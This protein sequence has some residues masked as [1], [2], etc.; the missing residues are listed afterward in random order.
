M[1]GDRPAGQRRRGRLPLRGADRR[2]GRRRGRPRPAARR[3]SRAAALPDADGR[4]R[5][6]GAGSPSGCS[7]SPA[8][9]AL[10]WRMSATAI[11]PVKRFGARQA[12]AARALDRPPARGA[13][14]RRCSPTCS[15][16][17]TA[18]R[19]G[20]ADD[21]RHRRGPRRAARPPARAAR[22][23]AARGLRDPADP[24]T[25][26]RRCSGSSARWRSAPAARRCCPGDCP[27]LDPARA[28]R[29]L[30]RG[31]RPVRVAVVPDRHGTGTNALL[32]RPP[33]R[34]ARRSARAAAARTRTAA[35][36]RRPS[37]GGRAARVARARPRHPGRPRARSPRRSADEPERAPA[38][39]RR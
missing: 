16:R 35:R 20:R 33:T 28:R 3:T 34:S 18:A 1:R 15:P 32:L 10:S 21:R 39:A 13:D 14:R 9:L 2:H 26:R 24:A 23:D 19:A 17:S 6:A 22:D 29:A 11:I 30:W 5:G 12:A 4:R 31:W 7:S 38:T 36:A 25:P 8:T 37:G 27:L